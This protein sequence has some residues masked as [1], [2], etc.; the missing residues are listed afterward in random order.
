M[1]QPSISPITPPTSSSN[2]QAASITHSTPVPSSTN[3]NTSNQP[4][5][6]SS[7]QSLP[8]KQRVCDS[9][10]LPLSSLSEASSLISILP[11][12]PVTIDEAN[13]LLG[14]STEPLA[15]SHSSMIRLPSADSNSEQAISLST[16]PSP[17]SSSLIAAS[18]DCIDLRGL[19]DISLSAEESSALA[20]LEYI[21]AEKFGQQLP[22]SI[23]NKTSVVTV[24]T[25]S[26]QALITQL[27][28]C[29]MFIAFDRRYKSTPSSSPLY[30]LLRYLTETLEPEVEVLR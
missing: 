10:S 24:R 17:P 5:F 1:R 9:P 11:N 4:L 28:M 30:K 18:S 27:N 19:L 22:A 12:Q 20:S 21:S 15:H 16:Q 25:L 29:M 8:K 6:F 3:S 13:L 26:R 2:E 7:E 14:P 23:L